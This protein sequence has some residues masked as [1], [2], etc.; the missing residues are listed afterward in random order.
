MGYGATPWQLSL[1]EKGAASA[2]P[3]KKSAD[4]A[5]SSNKSDNPASPFEKGGLR[6][7]M[8][9]IARTR[10]GKMCRLFEAGMD[11]LIEEM[12]EELVA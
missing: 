8:F 7:I 5:S 1:C 2:S 11:G 4:P 6:G 9:L 3:F 12:N 10:P